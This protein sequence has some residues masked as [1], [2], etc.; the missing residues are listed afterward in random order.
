MN[1]FVVITDECS[2]RPTAPTCSKLAVS[3]HVCVMWIVGR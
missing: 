3:V 2:M 1:V